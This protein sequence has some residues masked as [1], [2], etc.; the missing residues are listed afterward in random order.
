MS[1]YYVNNSSYNRNRSIESSKMNTAT[2]EEV[3]VADPTAGVNLYSV[4]VNNKPDGEVSN[5][6]KS[7]RNKSS[8]SSSSSSAAPSSLEENVSCSDLNPSANDQQQQQQHNPQHKSDI[9][10]LRRPTWFDAETA[11][12]K[13]EK[14]RAIGNSTTLWFRAGL[15]GRFYQLGRKIN[16]HAIKTVI[17]S[18]LLM[19]LFATGTKSIVYEADIDRLWVEGKFLICLAPREPLVAHACSYVNCRRWTC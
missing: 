5:E 8:P 4:F 2:D 9:Y 3:V 15:Q 7:I 18:I 19:L 16:H 11:I 13:I 12:L 1:N 10:W 17:T 6:T 14:G